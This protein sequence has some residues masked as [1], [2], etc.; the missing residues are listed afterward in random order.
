MH[1][2]AL[3]RRPRFFTFSTTSIFRSVRMSDDLTTLS[4]STTSSSSTSSRNYRIYTKTGDKGTSSLYNGQRRSKG[5]VFFEALGDVD[6]LNG[7]IGLCRE[8]LRSLSLS[9]S[10]EVNTLEAQLAEIQSRLLDVGSAIATP[11]SSSTPEQLLRA[12]FDAAPNTSQLEGW[13]DEF[14]TALPPLRNF[15]LPSGGLPSSQLH[16]ARSVC[17]RAERRAFELVSAGDLDES[18]AIYLNRLSDYLF[19]AARM[20]CKLTNGVETVYKKRETT[21][22]E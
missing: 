5:D 10:S 19:M 13:I 8:S 7:F 6:E 15:I 14:D 3:F 17:R 22:E 4:S 20:A 1:G 21:V 18:T 16:V 11:I 2:L 9:T 12:K